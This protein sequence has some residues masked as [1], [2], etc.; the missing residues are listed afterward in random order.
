MTPLVPEYQDN[1]LEEVKEA[2]VYRELSLL[3]RMFNVAR[4]QWRWVKEN[5][6]SDGD[7][8]FSVSK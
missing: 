8:S 3:R 2:T 4:K 6:V 1:R 5:P 7:L